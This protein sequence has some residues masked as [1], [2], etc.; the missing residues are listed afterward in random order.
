MILMGPPGAGK[1]TQAKL[2]QQRLRVPHVSSGD[3]LRDAVRRRSPM[4]LQAKRFM[5]RGELVPDAVVLGAV[6]E[7]LRQ[8]DC[9][10]GFIL[11]GFPRTVAQ[12]DALAALLHRSG[13]RI[14]RVVSL[15]VPRQDLV[16][17]LSG[18]RTCRNCGTMYHII[19]DPPTNAGICNKCQGDLYQ[20]DDDHEDTIGARLD[21]YERQTA[22]LLALYRHQSLLCEIDGVGGQ[23]QVLQRL[24]G[25]VEEPA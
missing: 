25:C 7:R 15:T 5:D 13:A 3:L 18:R 14:D 6:E 21:V 16:K 1:G 23:E 17:R 20:R 22:P 9:A 12:A 4:G 10:D 8:D 24:V 19:F 2:L 11:D